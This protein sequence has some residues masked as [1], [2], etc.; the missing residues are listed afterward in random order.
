MNIG[1]FSSVDNQYKQW[2]T[3]FH[4]KGTQKVIILITKFIPLIYGLILPSIS[5]YY[6]PNVTW[7][8]NSHQLV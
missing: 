8:F 6:V 2:V 3:L 1:L 5:S 4:E 7:I